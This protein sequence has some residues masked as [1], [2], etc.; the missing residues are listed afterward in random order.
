M[1]E[2]IYYEEI[3][4]SDPRFIYYCERRQTHL[5]KLAMTLALVRRGSQIEAQDIDD[6]TLI[7]KTT[8]IG[9][10]DALGEYGLSPLSAAKQ[11]MVEFLRH[12]KGPVNSNILWAV[13]SRE[14]KQIDF[15]NSLSDLYNANKI[16]KV[17]VDGKECFVYKTMRTKE[18][19]DLM[20][21]LEGE[22]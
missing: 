15:I 11:K 21:D 12:A 22:L 2:D 19:D 1:L 8:E 10:T 3:R 18:M 7:L 17:S 13:M 20:A 16:D 4:L 5:I 6:A 9:M 14:M